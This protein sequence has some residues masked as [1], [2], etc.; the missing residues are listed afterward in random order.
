MRERVRLRLRV[1]ESAALGYNK[2]RAPTLR[3]DLHLALKDN[4]FLM[5]TDSSRDR[6]G[7]ASLPGVALARRWVAYVQPLHVRRLAD[8]TAV[9]MFLVYAMG[10]LVTSTGSGH[11]CGNSWPLCNGRFVPEFAVSTAIEFSHRFVTGIITFLVIGLAAG[12]WW[13][14][15]A[16][17]EIRILAPVMVLALF[18]EALLGALLVLAKTSAFVLA[19]HF[20]S[21]LILF[22]SVLLTALI[23]R[24]LDG[25]DRLRDRGAPVGLR[26]LAFALAGYTYVVG[27]LGAYLRFRGVELACSDWPLCNGSAFPGFAGAVGLVF[28]HR[29]AALL[30]L[31]GTGALFAWAWRRREQRPD[32]ARGA[33]W[34]LGLVLAQAMV[35]ALVVFSQL[36]LFSKLAHA[37]LVALLFGALAY[38][39]LQTLPRPAAARSAPVPSARGKLT[40]T[41]AART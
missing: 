38:V 9:G 4:L 39:C 30:L 36:S 41:P 31:L 33:A 11:G 22:T 12:V 18:G 8:V 17:L 24:G 7:R 21:S 15:R 34:A 1:C 16:R 27:Y 2:A 5:K 29:L 20:G 23:V 10:T 3:R 35:G 19:L 37:G 26:W 14:W 28:T 13:F 6:S 32:V 25:A 40:G